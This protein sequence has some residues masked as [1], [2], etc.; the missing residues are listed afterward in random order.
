MPALS[1]LGKMLTKHLLLLFWF[2]GILLG[3]ADDI[4]KC[5]YS[6]GKLPST[7]RKQAR[8]EVVLAVG[9]GTQRRR[10][11]KHIG[12][13]D[14][15]MILPTIY[16]SIPTFVP[17]HTYASMRHKTCFLPWTYR[18][19]CRLLYMIVSCMPA[20]FTQSLY[21]GHFHALCNKHTTICDS[22]HICALSD[23]DLDIMMDGE[24]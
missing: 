20:K 14:I 1:S 10:E 7:H 3:S 12:F 19:E 9:A 15:C 2:C 23:S 8:R 13:S 22:C 18:R 6:I 21:L 5:N 24:R 16:P 4:L 17:S 11:K